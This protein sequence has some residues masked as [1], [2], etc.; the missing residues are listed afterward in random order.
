[1]KKKILAMTFAVAMCMSTITGCAN[2]AQNVTGEQKPAEIAQEDSDDIVLEEEVDDTVENTDEPVESSASAS[3]DFTVMDATMDNPAKIGEWVET[4]TYADAKVPVY[5]RITGL[6]RGDEAQKLVD[7]HNAKVEGD[8]LKQVDE[9]MLDDVEYCVITYEVCFPED[10][11]DEEG[12]GTLATRVLNLTV[13][14]SDYDIEEDIGTI[15]VKDISEEP[16]ESLSG[17][18]MFTDGKAAFVMKK[19]CTDYLLWTEYFYE[20]AGDDLT[21]QNRYVSCE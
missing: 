18:R 10:Y 20:Y 19:G 5:F 8:P 9:L 11:P 1:M 4:R 14:G 15:E 21:S 2:D 3:V 6:I 17:T 16:D 7:E 12:L 13:C